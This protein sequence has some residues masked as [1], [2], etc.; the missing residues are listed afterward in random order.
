LYLWTVFD[1]R[2]FFCLLIQVKQDCTNANAVVAQPHLVGPPNPIRAFRFQRQP[3][4]PKPSNAGGEE[5]GVR[6][7]HDLRFMR[8]FMT[9]V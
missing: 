8:L 2:S 6:R 4:R 5:E 3:S 7:E 9:R 1:R